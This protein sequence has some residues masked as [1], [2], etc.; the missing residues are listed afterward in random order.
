M[1]IFLP[2]TISSWVQAELRGKVKFLTRVWILPKFLT[3]QYWVK[4]T[5]CTQLFSVSV[6]TV[7]TV[8]KL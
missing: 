8:Y 6:I 2:P 7:I 1:I 4:G 3:L 5:E